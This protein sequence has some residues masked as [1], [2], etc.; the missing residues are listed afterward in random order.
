MT[1]P[2]FD[3]DGPQP[4]VVEGGDK[5][6]LAVVMEGSDSSS[7]QPLLA[8]YNVSKSPKTASVRGLP[9][10]LT[11]CVLRDA[12]GGHGAVLRTERG[13]AAVEVRTSDNLGIS[14]GADAAFTL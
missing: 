9:S 2:Q 6:V 1:L 3:R 13:G 7:C 11:G 4:C 14:G 8:L 5:A 10:S 12:L